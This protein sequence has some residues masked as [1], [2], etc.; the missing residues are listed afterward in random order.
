VFDTEFAVPSYL[1]KRLKELQEIKQQE[2]DKAKREQI[3]DIEK[4]LAIRAR[5]GL[6][7]QVAAQGLAHWRCTSISP[8]S[9]TWE[10]LDG[11][12]WQLDLDS[13]VTVDWVVKLGAFDADF[14]MPGRTQNGHGHAEPPLEEERPL[15]STLGKHV[16]R[17]Y[18]R[19][20][21]K[22]GRPIHKTNTVGVC[23]NCYDADNAVEQPGNLKDGESRDVTITVKEVK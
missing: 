6:T 11:K 7:R 13:T 16:D 20:C 15:V 12:V 3:V 9:A 17:N 21:S 4:T 2:N 22:C 18:D 19:Q 8:E 23:A 10:R 14:P 5:K 1:G